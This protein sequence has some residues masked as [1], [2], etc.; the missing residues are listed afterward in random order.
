[1]FGLCLGL[2]FWLLGRRSGQVAEEKCQEVAKNEE[3]RQKKAK[4]GEKI[5]KN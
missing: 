2:A 4:N 5:K 3:K 1:M